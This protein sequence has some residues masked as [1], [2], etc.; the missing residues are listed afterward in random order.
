MHDL[1]IVLRLR[2]EN[3]DFYNGF[4]LMIAK[5]STTNLRLSTSVVNDSDETGHA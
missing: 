5:L 2:S 1:R 4:R 3:N